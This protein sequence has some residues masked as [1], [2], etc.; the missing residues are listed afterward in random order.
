MSRFTLSRSLFIDRNL[1]QQLGTLP[2]SSLTGLSSPLLISVVRRPYSLST[3]GDHQKN[4]P[5]KK[6]DVAFH[7]HYLQVHFRSSRNLEK[8][9]NALKSLL[10]GKDHTT[11]MAV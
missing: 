1:P 8:T 10:R 3:C 4:Q 9:D 2:A 7:L 5:S 11:F 6:R